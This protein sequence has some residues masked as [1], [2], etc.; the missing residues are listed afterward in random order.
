MGM[1][2][3][4]LLDSNSTMRDPPLLRRCL[5]QLGDH[6][7]PDRSNSIL[8]ETE[9]YHSP[10][11]MDQAPPTSFMESSTT[12]NLPLPDLSKN[13]ILNN[14]IR[15]FPSTPT[16]LP[17]PFLPL[18]SFLTPNSSQKSFKF[19]F[20]SSYYA[21]CFSFASST[22]ILSTSYK[23]FPSANHTHPISCHLTACMSEAANM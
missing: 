20:F 11:T 4:A 21:L 19:P 10:A 6:I 22:M 14:L 2:R 5:G 9:D 15:Y 16:V 18:F 17:S 8:C 23:M 12:L 13:P 1:S 3:D 7:Y